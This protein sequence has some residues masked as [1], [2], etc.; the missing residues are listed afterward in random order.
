MLISAIDKIFTKKLTIHQLGN[1]ALRE[2][3]QPIVNVRDRQIQKLIDEM[4]V[5]LKQSKGVGLA[6]PQV[7]SLQLIIIASHPN[8]RYPNAPQNGTNCDD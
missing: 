3:A 1:S 5:T 4:L 7:G 8:E 2:M 6:A